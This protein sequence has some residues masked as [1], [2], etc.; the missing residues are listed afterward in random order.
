MLNENSIH[1][2]SE[3]SFTH[4]YTVPHNNSSDLRLD[5]LQ[6]YRVTVQQH[7]HKNLAKLLYTCRFDDH[8]SAIA[9]ITEPLFFEIGRRL[10]NILILF[11]L[12]IIFLKNTCFHTVWIIHFL[13]INKIHVLQCSFSF[14]FVK[15][16]RND[17][18]AYFVRISQFLLLITIF[19]QLV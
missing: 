5:M 19:Y 1:N 9:V 13:Q 10:N 15:D 11:K 8:C 17:M 6:C 3:N 7:I 2:Y 18:I 14:C 4:V 12:Q 16:R